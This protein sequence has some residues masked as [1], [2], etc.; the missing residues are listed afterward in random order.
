MFCHCSALSEV[1]KAS[2]RQ[3]LASNFHEPINQIATQLAVLISKVARYANCFCQIISTA[4]LCC[5]FAIHRF[6]AC[7]VFVFVSKFSNLG[8]LFNVFAMYNSCIH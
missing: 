2:L 5:G 7:V 6:D 4:V 8:L 1:E 3:G